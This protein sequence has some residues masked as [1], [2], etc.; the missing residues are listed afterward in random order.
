MWQEIVHQAIEIVALALGLLGVLFIVAGSAFAILQF[1]HRSSRDMLRAR[2]LF[3]TYTLLGLSF[4]VG[5]DV[6]ETVIDPSVSHL[7][8]LGMI[9]VIRIVLEYFLGSE[10]EELGEELERHTELAE[11]DDEAWA[12]GTEWRHA[13]AGQR[14]SSR[15]DNSEGGWPAARHESSAEVS[16]V[17]ASLRTLPLIRPVSGQSRDQFE[18]AQT[19]VRSRSSSQGR[20][21]SEAA[22]LR[23]NPARRRGRS[24]GNSRAAPRTAVLPQTDAPLIHMVR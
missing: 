15:S 3:G 14:G 16:N 12:H 23:P 17:V 1:R 21:L 20:P 8:G 22:S 6:V 4:M 9:I 13:G 7:A 2:F 10:V 18:D 24:S 19:V 11:P 5:Q